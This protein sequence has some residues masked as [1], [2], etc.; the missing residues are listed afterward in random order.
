[1]SPYGK[2]QGRTLSIEILTF[3]LGCRMIWNEVEQESGGPSL[4]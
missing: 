1:M 2:V 4:T 3:L